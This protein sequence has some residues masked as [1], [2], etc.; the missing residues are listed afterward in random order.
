MSGNWKYIFLAKH[1]GLHFHSGRQE[2][3]E[4]MREV[5]NERR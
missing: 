3:Y 5:K 2:Q 4:T 1:S